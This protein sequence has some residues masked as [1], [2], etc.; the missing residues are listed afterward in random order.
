MCLREAIH[1]AVIL[2]LNRLAEAKRPDLIFGVGFMSYRYEA[3]CLDVQSPQAAQALIEMFRAAGLKIA[4]EFVRVDPIAPEEFTLIS[5]L[6]EKPDDYYPLDTFQEGTY[7]LGPQ[8]VDDI[9]KG[10]DFVTL[11][12]RVALTT[13]HTQFSVAVHGET[14]LA[15]VAGLIANDRIYFSEILSILDRA[16]HPFR[17]Y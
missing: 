6:R 16:A 11:D 3:D 2:G 10:Q 4:D 1:R 7:I 15:D 13:L 14:L 9:F 5:R 17:L 12:K 8:T